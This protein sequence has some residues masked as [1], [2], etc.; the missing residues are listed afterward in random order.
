MAIFRDKAPLVEAATGKKPA[1]APPPT[2]T[3][4]GKALLQKVSPVASYEDYATAQGLTYGVPITNVG[5]STEGKY[6]GY[7]NKEDLETAITGEAQARNMAAADYANTIRQLAA[8]RASQ[9]DKLTQSQLGSSYYAGP[10]VAPR[11]ALPPRARELMSFRTQQMEGLGESQLLAEQIEQTPISQYARAIATQRYGLNPA[12]AAGMFGPEYELAQAKQQR[13][14]QFY[15]PAEGVLGYE[16]FLKQQDRA[17]TQQQRAETM[18]QDAISRAIEARDLDVLANP[19]LQ[20]QSAQ[21]RDLYY[22]DSISGV[23]GTNAKPIIT[24]SGLTPQ[25]AYDVTTKSFK[26]PETGEV[27]NFAKELENVT[28]LLEQRDFENAVAQV[29]R[30]VFTEAEPVGRL[31]SAYIVNMARIA[32]KPLK[33]YAALAT[34]MDIGLQ[35]PDGT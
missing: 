25:Q 22:T 9:V 8:E 27:I 4:M 7:Y 15:N 13:E 11:E 26:L 1:A 29:N 3:P 19:Q 2:E 33:D 14:M 6:G 12:L 35:N 23:L 30:L 34:A 17:Y 21:V 18:Q 16:D 31:L 5:L 10:Y 32:G 28:N 24:A 20:S